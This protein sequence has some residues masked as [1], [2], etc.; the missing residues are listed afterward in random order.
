MEDNKQTKPSKSIWLKLIMNSETESMNRSAWACTRSGTYLLWLPVWWFYG[1]PGS[2]NESVSGSYDFS[3]ALFSS[4]C[5]VQLLCDFFS[6][7]TLICCILI[8]SLRSLFF[9]NDK[10]EV[11]PGVRRE[12]EKL[13]KV[14]RG[15]TVISL[16]EKNLFSIK[17][18][19]FFILQL[20]SYV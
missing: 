6:Y 4:V 15:E 3:W 9:P 10:R 16:I 5:L 18:I 19:F 17:E 1:T 14:E 20:H 12:M 13:E 7:Y 2:E 8:L 11:D